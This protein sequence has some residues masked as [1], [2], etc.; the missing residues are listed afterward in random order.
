MLILMAI[1]A[2]WCGPDYCPPKREFL[3]SL[4]GPD[5][6]AAVAAYKAACESQKGAR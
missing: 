5:R 6:H 2:A 3:K 4:T 1:V